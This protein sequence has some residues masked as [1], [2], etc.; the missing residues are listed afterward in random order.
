M[1]KKKEKLT[2]KIV[3]RTISH[4]PLVVCVTNYKDIVALSA[5]LYSCYSFGLSYLNYSRLEPCPVCRTLICQDVRF[6]SKIVLLITLALKKPV[7]KCVQILQSIKM[8]SG[9]AWYSSLLSDRIIANDGIIDEIQ[10]IVAGKFF[11]SILFLFV[12]S[13]LHVVETTTV[14]LI[15]IINR[16]ENNSFTIFY[17]I[18]ADCI[19]IKPIQ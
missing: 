2:T 1:N 18:R 14:C 9:S 6:V 8:E 17:N 10:S 16:A 3:F 11:I 5:I 19:K 15:Y 12:F 4:K 13:N 7:N